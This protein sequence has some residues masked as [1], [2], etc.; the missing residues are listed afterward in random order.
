MKKTAL[1]L[2]GG[3]DAEREVSLKSAACVA[4]ALRASGDF[5]VEHRVVGRI[6]GAELRSLPGDVVWPVLHGPFGEG[7]P[8]QDLLETDGRPY[9]GCR[10]AAA[11]LAMDKVATK[12]AAARAGVPTAACA[13][14]NPADDACPIALP[15]VLKPIF[16]GS[17]IGLFICRTGAEWAGAR[18]QALASG[19]PYMVEPY[20][21]GRELTVGVL[22]VDGRLRALPAIEIVP[23]DGL[24]DY[25]AKYTRDDTQYLVNP[26]LPGETRTHVVSAA[27]GLCTAMGVRGLARADFMLPSAGGGPILLEVNTM[28]GFTDHSLVPMAARAVGLDMPALCATIV[29][30]ALRAGP[31]RR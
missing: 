6:S 11:R 23:A 26:V 9:V 10:P 25:E 28:P 27:V 8:M 16:E 21:P 12:M 22:E 17:T 14:L 19:K 15:V 2:A 24:Y 20:T 3:P 4:E 30:N 7:G 31:A 29:R 18:A 5:S 1:V 13:V